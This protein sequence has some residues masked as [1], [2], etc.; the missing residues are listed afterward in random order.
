MP[1]YWH[2]GASSAASAGEA[3]PG[4]RQDLLRRDVAHAAVMAEPADRL[5]AWPAGQLAYRLDRGGE[6]V[7]RRPVPWAGRA[8]NADR[9]RAGSGGHMEQA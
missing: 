3:A 9:R 2:S 6:R 1:R 5:V 7:E 4:G 8:E